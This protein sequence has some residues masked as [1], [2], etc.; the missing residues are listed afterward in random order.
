MHLRLVLHDGLRHLLE[1]GRLTSL[2]RRY[3]HTTLALSDRCQQI[4]DTKRGRASLPRHLEADTLIRENR[5]QRLEAP[6]TEHLGKRLAVHGLDVGKRRIALIRILRPRQTMDDIAGLQPVALDDRRIHI[7]IAVPRHEVIRARKAEAVRHDLEDAAARIPARCL[8]GLVVKLVRLLDGFRPYGLAI[9]G[10]R[11]S[12]R[13]C[14]ITVTHRP[15][16]LPCGRC[17]AA[18]GV[19]LRAPCPY[20]LRLLGQT[21]R[22]CCSAVCVVGQCLRRS[23]GGFLR[24]HFGCHCTIR[25]PAV[26]VVGQCLRRCLRGFLHRCSGYRCTILCRLRH[27]C[28]GLSVCSLRGPRALRCRSRAFRRLHLCALR[29]RHLHCNCRRSLT[30]V[31][32]LRLSTWCRALQLML[33]Y[34][35]C[36][37][38]SSAGCT[39]RCAFFSAFQNLQAFFRLRLPGT[40]RAL[41][42]T[43]FGHRSC[44]CS[45][46]CLRLPRTRRALRLTFFGHRSQLC[47][48]LCLHL[49]CSGS[50]LRLTLFYCRNRLCTFFC[51][52]LPSSRLTLDC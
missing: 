3:D 20:T 13:R 21:S 1:Q 4:E 47:T 25:C 5:G 18:A 37:R 12:I 2:R 45:F 34:C 41:R 6:P 31:P 46:F 48:F 15:L 33:F 7:N 26:R 24:R 10:C 11:R 17:T 43:L 22:L 50:T 30:G 42:F 16:T 38:L 19:C 29:H 36:L 27:S 14:S 49:A 28:R 23:S 44:L 52:R 32:G 51:L 39:L 35:R 8:L 9:M 40:G